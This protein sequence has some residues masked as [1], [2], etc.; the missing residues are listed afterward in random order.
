MKIQKLQQRNWMTSGK[1]VVMYY[2]W[3]IEIDKLYIR[4][5][6][7]PRNR[8]APAG[9][10]KTVCLFNALRCSVCLRAAIVLFTCEF[11]IGSVWQRPCLAPI[12]LA[13]R[14]QHRTFMRVSHWSRC[15][16]RLAKRNIIIHNNFKTICDVYFCDYT[17]TAAIRLFASDVT[18]ITQK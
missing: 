15:V 17:I 2:Y 1:H 8:I 16:C 11:A 10:T 7:A 13:A 14:E 9:T 3:R 5:L 4:G 18:Y 12:H 6:I